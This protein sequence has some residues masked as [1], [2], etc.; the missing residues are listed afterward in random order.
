MVA[1]LTGF[2]PAANASGVTNLFGFDELDNQWP[3]IWDNANDIRIRIDPR[4][5]CEW[6]GIASRHAHAAH[7]P[8]VAHAVSQRRSDA[9]AGTGRAGI[10]RAPRRVVPGGVNARDCLLSNIFGALVPNSTLTEGAYVQ[11]PPDP[12]WWIPSGCVFYSAGD[13]DTPAQELAAAE[14]NFF[15]PRRAVDPFGAISRVSYDSYDLL[16]AS[17]TDAVGNLT[18]AVNDYRVLQPMQVTDPNGN[19]AQVAFDVLGMVVGS[20]VMGKV[21]EHLGDSLTGF[22][23]DLDDATI[24]AHMDEP[25]TAPGVVLASATTRIIY[26][27]AAYYRTGTAPPAVYT[28][29]RETNVS[30]LNGNPTLYQHKFGYSDGFGRVIQSKG[31]AAPGPLS[32]GGPVVTPRWVGSGWT[33]FNNKGKPVRQYEPF[34][35]PTNAFEFAAING[36]S[37][38]LFYDPPGRRVATLRPDNTWE[39]T[40]FDGWRQE[41]WDGNDTVLFSDPRTDPNVGDYIARMLGTLPFT[42]WHDLRIA[43]TYGHDSGRSSGAKGR[44]NQDRAALQ[45]PGNRAPRCFGP[46]LPESRR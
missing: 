9:T 22:V 20:A 27:I 38:V 35:S 21:T 43:G 19:Q 14:A 11:L 17:F 33:I 32:A 36:V 37:S 6:L 25:L 26:D 18:S 41:H 45:D 15:L 39:K 8:R 28:L 4:L 5:G 34:F 3:T 31:Q 13:T 10:A 30:D 7:R 1:E 23:P 46:Y 42:S 29:A 44:R 12:N 24:V 16:P 2:A 40:I